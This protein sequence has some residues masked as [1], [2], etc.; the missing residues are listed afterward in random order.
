[1]LRVDQWWPVRHADTLPQ[2]ANGGVHNIAHQ[3]DF[4]AID[5][6]F[7]I[8]SGDDLPAPA[9]KVFKDKVFPW[10][11]LDGIPFTEDFLPVRVD[12]QIADREVGLFVAICPAAKGFDAGK[13][14]LLSK[15][16]DEIVVSSRLETADA[17]VDCV[18]CGQAENMDQAA[19]SSQLPQD[20]NAVHP[21]QHDVKDD[22][23]VAV[24]FR[25]PQAICA[26]LSSVHRV[27]RLLEGSTDVAAESFRIFDKH[28][29]HIY[30][31]SA[32]P[33]NPRLAHRGD[34]RKR[35]DDEDRTSDIT[36]T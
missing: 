26:V 29:S 13:Q 27:P 33:F 10:F 20:G 16:L 18:L 15:G 22:Y 25:E 30:S 36:G 23:V 32:V 12:F 7:D 24:R 6:R 35:T 21:R 5:V 4:I 9:R 3:I 28:D 17:S 8:L 34:Q 11:Q 31:P 1:V 19:F 14:F 2:R